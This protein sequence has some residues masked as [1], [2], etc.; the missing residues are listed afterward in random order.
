MTGPARRR[1]INP[2]RLRRALLVLCGALI[3]L[4]ILMFLNVQI[5]ETHGGTVE[6]INGQANTDALAV[7]VALFVIGL[8][9]FLAALGWRPGRD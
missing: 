8:A 6:L 4:S 3:A 1:G 2:W 7:P 9:G 5:S